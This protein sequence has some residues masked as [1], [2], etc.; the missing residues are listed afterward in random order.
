MK[1][2]TVI[3]MALLFTC[4]A[5]AT[6]GTRMIGFSAQTIGRGGTSFGTFDSPSLMMTNPAGIS[7]LNGSSIDA[8]F[9]LM[10]PSL[11]YT[12]GINDAAGKT[13]YFPLPGFGYVNHNEDNPLTWGFGAFTLGGMGADFTLN[14]ALYGVQQEYHSKLAVMQGGPS[15]AYKVSPQF[16]IGGS[17]HLVYSQLEFRMPYSLSPSV[18]KGIVN[19]GTGMTFGDM[20]SG[21]PAS[22]GFGYTEVTASADMSGLTA[23][24]FSAKIGVAYEINDNISVGLSYSSSSQLTYKNGSASMDMTA[25]M[26]NAFGL[27]MQGYMA[28]NPSATQQEAQAAVMAQ[29]TSLG[30]D[31]SKGVAANYNLEA[32]LKMPQSIGLGVSIKAANNFRISGDFEWVNWKN[33]WDNMS[34]SL[35]NGDNANINTMLGNSGNFS[36]DFPLNWKDQ[37]CFS[38]GGEYDV[39][40]TLTLRAGYSFGNNPV[41]EETIFPVFPAIIENHITLGASYHVSAPV[42]IHAAYELAISKKQTAGSQSIIANEYNN[43]VS[44]LGENIF[45]VS[46]SWMLE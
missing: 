25:Q 5:F 28:Q 32:K 38:L 23:Y 15:V 37:T 46:L 27:A 13:N 8:S 11:H 2:V 16:S 3:F 36:L 1:Q 45:H 26:N 20:F 22:G 33:A 35:S 19:P 43:S 44:E 42:T 21:P 24:G 34:I 9:S 31:L 29:F 40:N 14:H 7:F 30:I 41:P 6:H 39:N 10:V 12:N 17:A 18:M 4:A